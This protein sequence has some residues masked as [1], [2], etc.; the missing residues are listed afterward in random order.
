[1][2]RNAVFFLIYIAP[3]LALV[4]AWLGWVTIQTN[5]MGWFLMMVGLVYPMGMAIVYW[6]RKAR[7]WESK[8]GGKIAQEERGDRSYWLITLGMIAAFYGPPIEYVYFPSRLSHPIWMKIAGVILVI[9]GIF[10]FVWARQIMR[11]YYTGH[12]SVTLRQQLVQSGPYHFIRHPA[13]LGYLWMAL[14]V[15]LGYSSIAGLAAVL[16]ILLPAVICRIR[17]EEKLLELHFGEEYRQYELRTARLIPG[18]W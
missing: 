13:Y 4:L 7:F 1:M 10:L 8:A 11:A 14:G 2:N 5:P 18:I 3:A 17:V 9:F 16:L 12:L 15:S 6:I